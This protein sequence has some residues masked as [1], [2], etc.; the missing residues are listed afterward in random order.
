MRS[1]RWWR[2]LSGAQKLGV[3]RSAIVVPALLRA[4][5][6]RESN[7]R[8]AALRS[9]GEINDE[10]AYPLLLAAMEDRATSVRS[11]DIVLAIGPAI[12]PYLLAR[13]ESLSDAGART[14]YV[15]LLGLLQEPAALDILLP[16]AHGADIDLRLEV[17]IALGAIGDARAVSALQPLL[18]DSDRQTRVE[19]ARA[20]GRI[21]ART[22]VVGLGSLLADPSRSVRYSAACALVALG[23]NGAAALELAVQGVEPLPKGIAEQ[24]LAE[25]ALGLI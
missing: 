4:A 18:G 1:L 2:R 17:I 5:V 22:S 9:L 12:S 3:M 13:F 19:A 16:L 20:L 23:A 11:V 21:G 24:A 10:R 25:Q 7:V 8:I 14:L 6:D 15:R